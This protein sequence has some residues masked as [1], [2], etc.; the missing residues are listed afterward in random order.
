[1]VYRLR[2][3]ESSDLSVLTGWRNDPVSRPGLRTSFMLNGE[4]QADWFLTTVSNR[5]ADHRYWVVEEL[6]L[7]LSACV[8]LTNL[9]WENRIAEI[10]L[11]TDPARR[12]QGI[13]TTA[14]DLVLREGFLMMGLRV[15]Y[16]ECYECNPALRF[17]QKQVERIGAEPS[18]T[19]AG[20]WL[21]GTRKFYDGEFWRS[22]AFAFQRQE[23]T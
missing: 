9:Q 23:P 11:L 6:V 20:V 10:S 18:M 2:P 14:F 1:M 15:I 21:P 13:G 19:A 3:I 22:Y 12:G 8:G 4:M 7:G 5:R 16:G 17:W